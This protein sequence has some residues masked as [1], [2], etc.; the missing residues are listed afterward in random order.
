[1][2]GAAVTGSGS[3]PLRRIGICVDDFGIHD[4]V[5]AAVN[6]LTG[7]GRLS[8]VSCLVEGPAWNRNVSWLR[9]APVDVGLHLN[10]TEWMPGASFAV[11]LGALIALTQSRALGRSRVRA[12]INAQLDA[13]ESGVGRAPDFIDGHQHVHQFPVV[14]DELLKALAGRYTRRP[15]L[16][17]TS[18]HGGG[19]GLEGFQ[20][21][22]IE[23]LGSRAFTRAA[24][25]LHFPLSG[26][27]LGVYG[28]GESGT[29]Y[30]ERVL[31][32][33]EVASDADLLMAHPSALTWPGDPISAAR[34]R[35][36]EFLRSPAFADLL[37]EEN[38]AIARISVLRAEKADSSPAQRTCPAGA[39]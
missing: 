25:E 21:R 12:A 18:C 2:T 6:E 11:S 28:L 32:W 8:A 1:M 23:T 36:F 31:R 35:E 4:G 9:R 7:S 24:R 10:L 38:I 5:C 33:L 29:S 16:R 22:V 20:G 37:E 30:G 34:V 14:R 19:S 17:S 3:R 27:L 13:F 39:S 26:K 15:W